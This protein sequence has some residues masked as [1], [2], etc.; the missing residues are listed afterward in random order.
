[1]PFPLG[2]VSWLLIGLVAAWSGDR[3]I[4][5]PR[6]LGIGPALVLGAGGAVLGGLLATALGFG[7]LLGFDLRSFAVATLAAVLCLLLL[8]LGRLPA[9]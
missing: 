7:G 5:G 6:R 4:P 3:L 8:A 1:M 2:L 9:T